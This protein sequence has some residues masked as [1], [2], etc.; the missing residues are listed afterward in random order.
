MGSVPNYWLLDEWICSVD[1]LQV[2]RVERAAETRRN[3]VSG[4][5]QDCR[6]MRVGAATCACRATPFGA[7]VLDNMV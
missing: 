3:S 7:A 1:F 2:R 5:H 4:C 6:A